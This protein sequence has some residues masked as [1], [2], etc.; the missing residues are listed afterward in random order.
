MTLDLRRHFKYTYSYNT[1]QNYLHNMTELQMK[2]LDGM[3]WTGKHKKYIYDR[4][5]FVPNAWA[6][7]TVLEDLIKQFIDDINM[8][9]M[10]L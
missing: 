4:L 3:G 7:E 2:R 9:I 1:N 8:E 10:R 5:W 6:S